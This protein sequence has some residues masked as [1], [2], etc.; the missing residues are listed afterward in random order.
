MGRAEL[1]VRE[2]EFDSSCSLCD[3]RILA[4]DTITLLPDDEEWVHAHCAEDE[5][6][7]VADLA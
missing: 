2:A 7:T 5:G 4:G 3:E 6:Y 1:L